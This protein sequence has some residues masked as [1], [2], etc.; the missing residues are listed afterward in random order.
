MQAVS[1][2][3]QDDAD[4][5]GHGHGHFLEV[6]RLGFGFGLEV[7]L[8]QFADPIDQFGHSLAKLRAEGFLGDAG[9]FDHV[10]EHGRHQ[11]LMVHVHVG[12][13]ACHRQRMRDV[14]FT[15]TTALA[16]VGLFGVEVRSAHQVDLVCAEVG[17]Q[18]IGEGVYAR[19]RITSCRGKG[20]CAVL[21][22]PGIGLDRLVGLFLTTESK[23]WL[24]FDNGFGSDEFRGADAFSDFTQGNDGRLVVF[25][26]HFRL[27][28]AG[29]QL[30]G[31][32][33][34]EHD[35]LKTVIHV[36]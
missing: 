32:L 3:N 11:A 10:M 34:R 35:Q 7:H 18:A 27:F 21:R 29:G 16:I 36:F 28:A 30:T 23:G 22:R 33:G 6:F 31:T 8:G 25:P 19:H 17:R 9:V 1:Q 13:D 26:C 4:I 5:P 20:T 24:N 12:E 2:L 15:A 14:G